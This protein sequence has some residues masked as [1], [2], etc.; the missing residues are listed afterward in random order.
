MEE[1]GWNADRYITRVRKHNRAKNSKRNDRRRENK[2]KQK[3]RK[4]PDG[5][6]N[7]NGNGNGNRKNGG[8]ETGKR[9]KIRAHNNANNIS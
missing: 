1:G 7:E 2:R 3:K 5:N 6:G 4:E 9:K 8:A